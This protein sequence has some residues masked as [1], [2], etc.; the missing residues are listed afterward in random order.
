MLTAVGQQR[1]QGLVDVGLD[2]TALSLLYTSG[3]TDH[4]PRAKGLRKSKDGRPT[5]LTALHQCGALCKQIGLDQ[6]GL[7]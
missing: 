4:D 2:A 5:E 1:L 7:D 6:V 3:H